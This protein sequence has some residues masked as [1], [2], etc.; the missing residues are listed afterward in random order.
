MSRN[1][2]TPLDHAL[3]PPLLP[4]HD[5][6][7]V[8][9]ADN[10]APT[11]A[12]LARTSANSSSPSKDNGEW[13]EI[14]REGEILA[15]LL[16]FKD[17]REEEERALFNSIEGADDGSDEEA[18]SDQAESDS[19][20]AMDHGYRPLGVHIELDD[21]ASGTKGFGEHLT[22]CSKKNSAV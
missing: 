7:N 12:A 15:N 19:S 21:A 9:S 11:Q 5:V 6:V 22:A 4:F 8:T 16:D 20:T 18:G 10:S 1:I 2:Y 13:S 14:L 3:A 17:P